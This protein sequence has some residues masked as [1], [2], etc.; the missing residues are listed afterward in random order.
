MTMPDLTAAIYG[1]S[2]SDGEGHNVR[3]AVKRLEVKGLVM[4]LG[5]VTT[6][7]AHRRPPRWVNH[8]FLVPLSLQPLGPIGPFY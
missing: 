8:V 6:T 7:A 2:W 1:P 4:R 5:I 3:A